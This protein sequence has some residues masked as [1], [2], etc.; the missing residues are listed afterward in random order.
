MA[1]KKIHLDTEEVMHV[2]PLGTNVDPI[3]MFSNSQFGGWVVLIATDLADFQ[4][5]IPIDN[6]HGDLEDVIVCKKPVIVVPTMKTTPTRHRT[7]PVAS[8]DPYTAVPSV[9]WLAYRAVTP[10]PLASASSVKSSPLSEP[11]TFDL[12]LSIL[13]E[14]ILYT[15]RSSN[16]PDDPTIMGP[17]VDVDDEPTVQLP[18][19]VTHTGPPRV[20]VTSTLVSSQTMMAANSYPRPA[21][22]INKPKV[23]YT[24]TNKNFKRKADDD[25][26]MGGTENHENKLARTGMSMSPSAER[27]AGSVAGGGEASPTVEELIRLGAAAEFGLRRRAGS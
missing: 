3:G 6:E 4:D 1:N 11:N 14:Q 13:D 16:T 21:Y 24:R 19:R 9:A 25:E 26:S 22:R 23:T 12:D 27:S 8:T 5:T 15:S 18:I 2:S 7:L 17:P 10:P 20:S